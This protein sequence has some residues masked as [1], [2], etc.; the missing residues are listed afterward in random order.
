MPDWRA[1]IAVLGVVLISGS[2]AAKP[3]VPD[4]D[5]VVLER[6]PEKGDP[7]LAQLKRMRAALA[8]NPRDLDI[9]VAVVR[10]AL[11]AA[12]TLGDPRFVGQAQAALTPWWKAND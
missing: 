5:A 10:R 1:A 8:A 9:A 2:V 3:F 11:E 12:R 7:A 4:S 6:L